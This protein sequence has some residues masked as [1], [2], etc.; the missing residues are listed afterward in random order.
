[1]PGRH[2]RR[3]GAVPLADY[4][5]RGG[6]IGDLRVALAPEAGRLCLSRSQRTATARGDRVS[7]AGSGTVLRIK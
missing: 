4:D 6:A 1:M 2:A 7:V 5:P 3:R